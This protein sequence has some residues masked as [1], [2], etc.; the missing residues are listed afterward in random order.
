M[1]SPEP[2][3]TL[4]NFTWF[5]PNTGN[6][7]ERFSGQI[8]D[9]ISAKRDDPSRRRARSDSIPHS[10]QLQPRSL[11]HHSSRFFSIQ[12]P[13]RWRFQYHGPHRLEWL[14]YHAT[15]VI[16]QSSWPHCSSSRQIFRRK[17]E[18]WWPLPRA[19]DEVGRKEKNIFEKLEKTRGGANQIFDN[20]RHNEL[21]SF[22][23]YDAIGFGGVAG[24]QG[25]PSKEDSRGSWFDRAGESGKFDES[26]KR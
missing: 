16:R 3:R 12:L 18:G 15:T 4:Q 24:Y 26:F 14:R 22:P 5:L 7:T 23:P 8:G 25:I 10:P 13:L 9:Y 17:G 6:I 19:S 21:W 11:L 20:S 1:P 2:I